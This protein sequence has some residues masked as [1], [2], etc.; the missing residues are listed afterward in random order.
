MNK[1]MKLLSV[2][3]LP[4]YR[5]DCENHK[6]YSLKNRELRLMKINK[7]YDTYSLYVNGGTKHIAMTRLE[8]CA[9]HHIHINKIDGLCVVRDKNGTLILKTRTDV[10]RKGADTRKKM[11]MAVDLA[12]RIARAGREYVNGKGV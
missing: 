12:E 1:N 9:L 8:Y 6:V 2:K 4:G 3:G 11:G 10:Q 7:A 5:I